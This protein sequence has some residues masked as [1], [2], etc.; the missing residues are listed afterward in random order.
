MKSLLRKIFRLTIFVIAGLILAGIYFAAP[1][2]PLDKLKDRYAGLPSQFIPVQ[3]LQV[4]IRDEG[5]GLPVLLL[6]GTSAS[7]HTWQGWVDRLS[8]DYRLIRVDLPGFGLT[9]P[10]KDHD[11]SFP[12][13]LKFVSALVDS[14]SLDTF[15]IAGN[16]LGGGIAWRYAVGRPDQ[17]KGLILIDAEGYPLDTNVTLAFRLARVPVLGRLLTI[18]TPRSLVE[19]SIKDVYAD[20]TKVTDMLVDRYYH[21][22]RRKGNRDALL[23]RLRTNWPKSAAAVSEVETPTLIMWGAQDTGTPLGHA[24]R[25]S[26]DIPGSQLIIYE[27]A[28]H[29]PMEEIPDRTAEDA[30]TFLKSLD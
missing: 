30:A 13:Y 14:L 6:H 4:H 22:A 21:L 23:K 20:D 12:A 24:R 10:R 3:G 5:S 7:L 25:F 19:K 16:S 28:G 8:R 11:Y 9:G 2:I 29:V 17:V 27:N 15:V 18:F 26:E 1:D